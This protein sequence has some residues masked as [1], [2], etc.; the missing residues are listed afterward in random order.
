MGVRSRRQSHQVATKLVETHTKHPH[1]QLVPSAVLTEESPSPN[2]VCYD[3]SASPVL[4]ANDDDDERGFPRAGP[5]EGMLGIILGLYKLHQAKDILQADFPQTINRP[6]SQSGGSKTS[7]SPVLEQRQRVPWGSSSYS[8][9]V[10]GPS[11]DRAAN[12]FTSTSSDAPEGLKETTSRD[13]LR[14][15]RRCQLKDGPFW[16]ENEQTV[17]HIAEA[18]RSHLTRQMYLV[19][20]CRALMTFGAP[21]HRLEAQVHPIPFGYLPLVVALFAFSLTLESQMFPGLPAP[22]VPYLRRAIIY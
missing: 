6:R 16:P 18:I 4:M 9:Q 8:T 14:K 3:R 1:F 15:Q 22:I 7:S 17:T 21:T 2:S 10:D 13:T 19:K 12:C 5:Q 20:L 11:S